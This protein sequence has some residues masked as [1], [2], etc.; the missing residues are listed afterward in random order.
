MKIQFVLK[1]SI[2]LLVLMLAFSGVAIAG[3]PAGHLE[4]VDAE[5]RD[6]II[7]NLASEGY[8]ARFPNGQD[9]KRGVSAYLWD[10]RK[11]LKNVEFHNSRQLDV[12]ICIMIQKG[13]G[14]FPDYDTDQTFLSWCGQ[15]LK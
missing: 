13:Y 8:M 15:M 9:V 11:A 4:S 2:L 6:S 3:A 12:L 1:R 10:H 5:I 7:Q 14:N